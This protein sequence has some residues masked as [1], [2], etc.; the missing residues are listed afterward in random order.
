MSE[1]VAFLGSKDTVA[2]FTP[3]GVATFPVNGYDSARDAFTICL[4][5][6]F[7][8]L[9]VTEEISELLE[10]ELKSIRF[11]PTPAVLV[12]PSMM[13]SKWLGLS[14]L[15]NLV[16]KAVGADILTRDEPVSKDAGGRSGA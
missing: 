11:E 3:L 9:F 5:N 10:K 6:R 15:R 8:I 12:V 1:R 7:A 2:G 16:E 4:K 13:G 14:R